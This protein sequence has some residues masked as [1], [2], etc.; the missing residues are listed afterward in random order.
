MFQRLEAACSGGP[1]QLQ[2]LVTGRGH[3]V[4]VPAHVI[5]T[6]PLM[7]EKIGV[8]LVNLG[9]PEATDYWSMRRYLK[10]F[11]SDRRVVE[12]PRI[13]WW[14]ILNLIILSTRPAQRGK[15]YDSIW[16][17]AR[18]ESPLKTTTRSQ[19][20]KLKAWIE[21]GSL[22]SRTA[23][24]IHVDW[25]MRYGQPS[26]EQGIDR[27]I[28]QGC[29]RLLVVPLYPQ[30]SASTTATVGDAVFAA[31]ARR[32]FQPALR[33]APPYYDAPAYI[34]ALATSIQNSVEKLAFAPEVILVSF[35]GIPQAYADKGDPYP[36]HCEESFRLLAK[37][38]DRGP[39]TVRMT[40]Q[41]RFGPAQWL[42]PYTD[43]TVK[44]LARQ[45]VKNLL[46]VTPG[47]AADCLE[48]LEEIDIENRHLFLANGGEN[49]AMVPC[50]N[51]SI[52]GM[53]VIQDLVTRELAGWV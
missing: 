35:H 48:T 52:E 36:R 31:L 4:R 27:L 22:G 1:G 47:F 3:E 40:Y 49:F 43:E 17:V 39:K 32:R 29:E 14:P 19:A 53:N 28:G 8:L 51:D 21:A 23:P 50:L 25:A 30:Y 38:L 9:T 5:S 24:N 16:N 45:G 42:T 15:A 18:N 10:E 37:L 13:L 26:I 7:T 6:G 46:V 33:L 20:E 12:T 41:S 11:L 34:A 44:E 2:R